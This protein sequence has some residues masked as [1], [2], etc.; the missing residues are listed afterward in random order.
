MMLCLREA[1][2]SQ[3]LPRRRRAVRRAA[4]Q[5]G[6]RPVLY[7]PVLSTS[8]TVLFPR[9]VSSLV[10][11]DERMQGA[12]DNAMLR[13]RQVIVVAQRDPEK[14]DIGPA[15]LHSIGTEASIAR[16]LK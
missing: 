3:K 2:I 13:D 11:D 16:V 8:D 5:T 10:V 6:D 1:R 7:L 12:I 9:M 14:D 15:D 4:N